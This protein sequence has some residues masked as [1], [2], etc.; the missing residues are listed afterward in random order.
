M[1][2]H[3]SILITTRPEIKN[4]PLSLFPGFRHLNIP[5]TQ[6]VEVNFNS[7]NFEEFSPELLIFTSSTGAFMFLGKEVS[8]RYSG[9]DC[10][11]IGKTT[12]AALNGFSSNISVP[13]VMDSS[14]VVD[15][16]SGGDYRSRRIAL[17]SSRQSNNAIRNFMERESYNFRSYDLYDA[18]P[19]RNTSIIEY[20]GSKDVCAIIVTSSQ[21][22]RVMSETLDPA[23]FLAPVYAIGNTT[24]REMIKLGFTVEP[25]IGNSEIQALANEIMRKHSGEWI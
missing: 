5:M 8:H 20:A 6:I 17:L 2:G 25:R 12:A 23:N 9:I 14:G 1:S 21:E 4:S 16:L 3:C 19:L 7:S 10:I 22:A 15:L 18:L 11:C 13:D 24:Y